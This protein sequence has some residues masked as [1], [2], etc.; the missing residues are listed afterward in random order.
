MSIEAPINV[1]IEQR[2]TAKGN[3]NAILQY[4]R[5]L[6]NRQQRLL[7]RLPSFNSHVIVRKREV[8][9]CDLAALTAETGVEYA[10][11]TRKGERLIVRGNEVM[12]NIDAATACAM[13]EAGWRWS[14]HTHPGVDELCLVSS[15]GDLAILSAFKQQQSVI[16][17][18]KGVFLK[19]WR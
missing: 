5:P 11:F 14:G 3:P 1:P 8:S 16:Y 15:N 9:M 12:T 18:A 2:N 4:G 6:N 10:M 17:N 19:F 7:E 13:A